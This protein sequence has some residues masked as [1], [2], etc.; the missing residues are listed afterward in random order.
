MPAVLLVETTDGNVVAV[1][2]PSVDAARAWEDSHPEVQAVGCPRL[3]SRAEAL[4]ESLP[5]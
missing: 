3:V 2:F 5:F 4:A 1:R